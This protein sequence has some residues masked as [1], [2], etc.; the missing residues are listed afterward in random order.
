MPSSTLAA[1]AP[2][3]TRDAKLDSKYV[4]RI[5]QAARTVLI[6][7]IRAAQHRRIGSAAA[8]SPGF[9]I[10]SDQRK[11]YDFSGGSLVDTSKPPPDPTKLD[12]KSIRYAI[13]DT[14]PLLLECYGA[15]FD[16]LARKDGTLE[17]KLVLV[18]EPGLATIVDDVELGGDAHLTRDAQLVECMRE[19]LFSI[20]M[21]AMPAAETW[22]VHYPLT[23]PGKR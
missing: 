15:A 10:A 8:A 22:D 6:D 9:S 5:D 3:D 11:T 13:H 7:R 23:M 1:A 4:R 17:V 18:G 2:V 21:P 20:E 19:T 14:G 12:K 16:R